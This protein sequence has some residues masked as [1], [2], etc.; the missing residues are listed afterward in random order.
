MEF[1]RINVVTPDNIYLA[2]VVIKGNKISKVKKISDKPA[3][4]AKY[5]MPGFID[6]HTHGG[7]G[8]DFNNLA[9][10]DLKKLKII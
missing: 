7:Y 3:A 4:N 6:S 2:D 1:K 10:N 5:M 9:R 8:W